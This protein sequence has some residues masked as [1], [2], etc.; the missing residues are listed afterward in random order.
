M[1]TPHDHVIFET[2][3][4]KGKRIAVPPTGL[5][6]GRESIND[7][8]VPDDTLS[9][10]HCRFFFRAGRLW[11]TDLKSANGTE[12]N[13]AIITDDYALNRG[14]VISIGNTRMR[15]LAETLEPPPG[16][17]E[18][19]IQARQAKASSPHRPP[20]AP[21]SLLRGIL[22]LLLMVWWLLLAYSL[23]LPPPGS[24][25]QISPVSVEEA[26]P[27]ETDIP[28]PPPVVEHT[29][30]PAPDMTG[31]MAD[32]LSPPPPDPMPGFRETIAR[33][34]FAEDYAGAAAQLAA[35][36]VPPEELQAMRQ[37][38][39]NVNA[40]NARIAETLGAMAGQRIELRHGATNLLFRV[41]AV[42]GTKV[43]GVVQSPT[44]EKQVSVE[45]NKLHPADRLEWL[46][47]PATPEAHALCAILE[48]KRGDRDAAQRH[49]AAAGLLADALPSVLASTLNGG[50]P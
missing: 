3:D 42:A 27:D 45:I 49:A 21:G 36:N 44:G 32:T 30:P 5:K 23:C 1:P 34:L 33:R 25:P 7:L 29:P 46:G 17:R 47:E 41:V 31:S 38:L 28:T 37:Y 24:T 12:V 48:S 43:R 15:V 9:R 2:G 22:W 35:T 10:S 39:A 11:V 20:S 14:D 16:W 50:S 26:P 18:R 6:I 13:H 8:Q 19:R 40:M 4:L